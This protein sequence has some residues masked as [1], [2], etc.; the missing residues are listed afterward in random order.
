MQFSGRS[1]AVS[2]QECPGAVKQARDVALNPRAY[3]NS[4]PKTA[5]RRRV[6]IKRSGPEDPDPLRADHLQSQVHFSKGGRNLN[7]IHR[8][9]DLCQHFTGDRDPLC[10]RVLA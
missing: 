3:N 6:S 10:H 9:P 5:K 4:L 8:I 1:S 7:P 2:S